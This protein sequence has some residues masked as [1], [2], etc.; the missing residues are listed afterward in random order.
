MVTD[1]EGTSLEE[2][3][4][5]KWTDGQ[6]KNWVYKPY[7][8]MSWI[9]K[10][11]LLQINLLVI[12]WMEMIHSVKVYLPPFPT[13]L[14]F[15]E[16]THKEHSPGSGGKWLHNLCLDKVDWLTFLLHMQNVNNRDFCWVSCYGIILWRERAADWLQIKID[17][18]E[19][20]HHGWSSNLSIVK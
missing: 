10:G 13:D 9:I 2:W 1:L 3:T 20:F 7:I 6:C 15:T 19:I 14:V 5:G 4:Q 16:G 8:A 12:R 17:Y 11:N 18:L